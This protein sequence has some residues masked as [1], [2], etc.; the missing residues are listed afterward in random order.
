M[1]IENRRR[2]RKEI[3]GTPLTN[4]VQENFRGFTFSGETDATTW[5]SEEAKARQQE[6]VTTEEF[7]VNIPDPDDIDDDSAHAG[8]YARRKGDMDVDF[9]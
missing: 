7:S 6:A 5:L 2:N 3:A 8:R 4:S 1:A 9:M